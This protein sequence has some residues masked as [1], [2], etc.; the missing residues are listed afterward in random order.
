M[1][2]TPTHD[3]EELDRILVAWE[4][5]ANRTLAGDSEAPLPIGELK[6]LFLTWHTKQLA[7]AS[8]EA[9]VAARL[10]E[11]DEA[12]VRNSPAFVEEIDLE[13]YWN[14]YYEKR[15]AALQAQ[16]PPKLEGRP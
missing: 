1:N 2:P 4:N 6:K 15:L 7:R 5:M 11:L 13:K 16:K 8:K 3:G 10:D 14:G 9:E 12:F